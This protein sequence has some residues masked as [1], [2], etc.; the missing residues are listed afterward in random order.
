MAAIAGRRVD[1]TVNSM[2]C[3]IVAAMRHAAEIFRLVF[4]GRL[5][6][7]SDPMAVGAI[8]LPVAAGTDAAKTA[9]HRPVVIGEIQPV[10]EL[11]IGNLGFVHLVAVGALPQVFPVLVGMPRR[12]CITGL[13]RGTGRQK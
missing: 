13:K 8:A 11:V 9:R 7:D 1:A 2:A 10:I 12:R 5:Q 3:Q 6:L 4:D